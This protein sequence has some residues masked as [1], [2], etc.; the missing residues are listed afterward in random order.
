MKRCLV[1]TDYYEPTPPLADTPAPLT[2]QPVPRVRPADN[3]PSIPKLNTP[4]IPKLNKKPSKH[5]DREDFEDIDSVAEDEEEEEEKELVKRIKPYEPREVNS[6]LLEGVLLEEG[7]FKMSKTGGEQVVCYSELFAPL[8]ET[9]AFYEK[10][11]LVQHFCK[12]GSLTEFYKYIHN[13][14]EFKREL[15]GFFSYLRASDAKM[16]PMQVQSSFYKPAAHY[17]VRWLRKRLAELKRELGTNQGGSE[18]PYK[19]HKVDDLHLWPIAELDIAQAIVWE[20]PANR[21]AEQSR[22]VKALKFD[23]GGMQRPK[24]LLASHISPIVVNHSE[25][26]EQTAH[27]ESLNLFLSSLI[28]APSTETTQRAEAWPLKTEP[29]CLEF[30][31]VPGKPGKIEPAARNPLWEEEFGRYWGEPPEAKL[32]LEVDRRTGLFEAHSEHLARDIPTRINPRFSSYEWERLIFLD[33]SDDLHKQ[34]TKV[35]YS[36]ADS[37]MHFIW[38][39]LPRSPEDS[40]DEASDSV[41]AQELRQR[42]PDSAYQGTAALE[43]GRT[44]HSVMSED[45]SRVGRYGESIYKANIKILKHSKPAYD[46]VFLK[47]NWTEYELFHF[48][49][50]NFALTLRRDNAYGR[51]RV[52][53]VDGEPKLWEEV[54]EDEHVTSAEAY[55]LQKHLSL[56]SGKFVL[57]EYIEK[58]P[59]LLNNSGMA[60]KLRRYYYKLR[61]EDAEAYVGSLGLPVFLESHES[62]PL[63]GQLQ[64]QQGLGVLESNLNRA[65]VYSHT[66][67]QTD[68]ALVRCH[69][70]TGRTKFY[71]RSLEYLY[72]VGQME[73][74]VE[75]F[76]PKARST[77]LLQQSRIQAYI[78]NFLL[79]ND[80]HISLSDITQ[81]FPNLN[82]SVIRKA[83][84]DNGCE[85]T[86]DMRWSCAELPS[87]AEV[88]AL[89]TPENVCQY[90]SML[91]G[92]LAL[93]SRGISITSTEKLSS[94]VQKL[95]QEVSDPRTAYLGGYIEEEVLVTPWNLTSSYFAAKHSKVV[96][97]RLEGLGD[98]TH[99]NC[100]YS[101]L[102]LPVKPQVDKST[103]AAKA[104]A[105][106]TSKHAAAGRIGNDADLRKLSQA[107]LK[108]RLIQLGC[109]ESRV[110]SLH[111]KDQMVLLR[112]LSSQAVAEGKEGSVTKYARAT[113]VTNKMQREEYHKTIND[114]LQRQI[115]MLGGSLDIGEHYSSDS[116]DELIANQLA[117]FMMQPI[118]PSETRLINFAEDEERFEMQQL[119]ALRTEKLKILEGYR[120]PQPMVSDTG[121][122]QV[123]KRITITRGLDGSVTERV[124][125]L[126][127]ALDVKEY[128][129]RQ[130]KQRQGL[131]KADRQKRAP[132]TI[133]Q[134]LQ[135]S[136]EQKKVLDETRKLQEERTRLQELQRF[137]QSYLN[138]ASSGQDSAEVVAGRTI[139]GKCGM[140]GHRRTNRKKCPMYALETME[141]N[142][143][144]NDGI[145]KGEGFK[146]SFSLEGISKL[147]S[148]KEKRTFSDDYLK[149]RTTVRRRTEENPFEE[150][151][152]SL[153][154]FDKTR[155]FIS[156]SKREAENDAANKHFDLEAIRVKAK[157]GEYTSP[158][159]FTDDLGQLVRNA[160][161]YS[162]SESE[163]S[164]QAQLIYDE[165]MR[166]LKEKDLLRP[167]DE[168]DLE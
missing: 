90:E 125:Y 97:M 139:C 158:Q 83:L 92:Q 81:A 107:E 42:R 102:K 34:Y 79:N 167:A 134:K 122:R 108:R 86:K 128:L 106:D 59:P 129:D 118:K 11:S 130:D 153:I 113:R 78:L 77:V 133:D 56:K 1:I 161:L 28:S 100:G 157:R 14:Q 165:G 105:T 98:P 146:L 119:E 99:G 148:K 69:A 62:W 43:D 36:L 29:I 151:A 9:R 80:N 21:C 35:V 76:T 156:P 10:E 85:K 137:S 91:A 58:Q 47:T 101:F 49:R 46:A 89:I 45:A 141:P 112:Q 127:S 25:G 50:P 40:S 87:H 17:E 144:E 138:K 166:L 19:R 117:D 57:F 162:G 12:N 16:L 159:A 63:L 70:A 110:D 103:D 120:P 52:K 84:K 15:K 39:D 82:E 72:T 61:P 114:I 53:V 116:E 155:L 104:P 111:R 66:P 38:P 75:V 32:N 121:K 136:L 96:L 4:S 20:G 8:P 150:I 60:S 13:Q 152:F 37:S 131:I 88:K 5:D 33:R 147:P 154:R 145:V 64:D 149:P 168:M 26:R 55:K 124:E 24:S 44:V 140:A 67:R 3:P 18:A 95:K 22:L 142:H 163:M 143:T 94:A 126:P 71:L 48:H 109:T 6:R 2:S 123:V 135:Q 7:A 65:A 30:E 132:N 27:K 115:S 164:S 68:F 41:L 23:D 73:P 93:H 51:S 54:G 31:P 74:K 160:Q